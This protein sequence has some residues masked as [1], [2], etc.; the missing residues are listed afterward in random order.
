MPLGVAAF[1]ASLL[2]VYAIQL[3]LTQFFPS[4]HPVQ[5][6][7]TSDSSAAMLLLCG[8][9]AV[10]VAPIAFV[11]EHS[12]T[13]V[14]LDVEYANLARRAGVPGYFR[15]PAQNDDA[16]FI[17]ALAGI[18]RRALARGPGLC[19]QEGHGICPAEH[20]DCPHIRAA[21]AKAA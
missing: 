8:F 17:A 6:L 21:L 13:L 7:L 19:S 12:E 3:V 16:G 15:A 9:S 18:A 4:H 5:Q 11:S 10:L 2:P 14:E 1:L 20:R